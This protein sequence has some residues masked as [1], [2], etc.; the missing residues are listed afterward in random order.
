MSSKVVIVIDASSRE[1][2]VFQASITA[3][4]EE[5]S[6]D[7]LQQPK[8]RKGWGPIGPLREEKRRGV[9]LRK[10][11][12]LG[13]LWEI[14]EG[15][16][17]SS[18]LPVLLLG[19]YQARR[20]GG[21]VVC[22]TENEKA[23]KM[24]VVG[25]SGFGF[26]NAEG[27]EVGHN[28]RPW[29]LK[30]GGILLP[31]CDISL[32][33]DEEP[34]CAIASLKEGQSDWYRQVEFVPH[35][36]NNLQVKLEAEKKESLFS[37]TSLARAEIVRAIKS[38]RESKDTTRVSRE[39]IVAEMVSRI[40]QK[41][42]EGESGDRIEIQLLK[43]LARGGWNVSLTHKTQTDRLRWDNH[44]FLLEVRG[45]DRWVERPVF[46]DHT[47]KRLGDLSMSTEEVRYENL[48][49]DKIIPLLEKVE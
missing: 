16:S 40:L 49:Y 41:E 42:Y 44:S 43:E 33:K 18:Q 13:S 15:R 14:L 11:T 5:V 10:T 46:M 28:L 1:T 25:G 47:Q 7:T 6:G 8:Y 9:V 17:F 32:L 23:E 39:E 35:D 37:L 36:G 45:S 22:S 19:G 30:L 31:P 27:K 29:G 48:F 3:L 4:K 12:Q 26:K 38:S 2:E 34:P 24:W 21:Y 20:S